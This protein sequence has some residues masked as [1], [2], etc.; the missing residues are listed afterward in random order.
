MS[1]I[2][3]WSIDP[4]LEAI[5][6]SDAQAYSDYLESLKDD[7]A[8]ARVLISYQFTSEKH[9]LEIAKKYP[10]LRIGILQHANCPNEIV[11]WAVKEG[12]EETVAALVTCPA[13]ISGD[14]LADLWEKSE[15]AQKVLLAARKDC[16]PDVIMGTWNSDFS[17][18][19]LFENNREIAFKNIASNPNIPKKLIA[20]LMKYPLDTFFEGQITL[21]QLLIK[22]PAVAEET[23]ALLALKGVAKKVESDPED[24]QRFMYWWPSNHAYRNRNVANKY[25]RLFSS[26]A[27][28]ESVLDVR[29]ELSINPYDAKV[30][31]QHWALEENHRIYKCLWPDLAENPNVNFFYNAS[32]WDGDYAYVG[33]V[34]KLDLS[35]DSMKNKVHGTQEWIVSSN[36][37]SFEEIKQEIYDRGFNDILESEPTEEIIVS[38]AIC[39]MDGNGLFT[40]TEKGKKYILEA[41]NEWFEDDV[42]YTAEA[43]SDPAQKVWSVLDANRQQVIADLIISSLKD[44][45]DE[46]YKFAEY[47]GALIALNP[48]TSEEIRKQL[49]ESPSAL[50]K[51]ALNV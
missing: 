22:N 13:E 28:P 12:T 38:A 49:N 39:E 21:G 25:R 43:K 50:I 14:D 23:K 45:A 1:E 24:I 10:E 16:P 33:I 19:S 7:I 18:D 5:K 6:A 9:L 42:T 46:N 32:S 29:E 51:Q 3:S 26:S 8:S 44:V 11:D 48:T 40:I 30:V 47:L 27:H 41:G 17:N 37:L 31:L 2:H 34:G 20:E 35:D 15:L 36:S 4:Y